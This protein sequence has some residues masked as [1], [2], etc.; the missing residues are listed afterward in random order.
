M[1]LGAGI[2]RGGDGLPTPH[3]Q[4]GVFPF[5][6]CV[7][8]LSRIHCVAPAAEFGVWKSAGLKGLECVLGESGPSRVPVRRTRGCT[9]VLPLREAP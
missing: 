4:M 1:G 8:T 6:R 3:S 9:R 2:G 7:E 5:L